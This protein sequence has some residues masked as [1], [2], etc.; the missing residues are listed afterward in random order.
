MCYVF[1]YTIIIRYLNEKSFILL[2]FHIQ[3]IGLKKRNLS[4]CA[5]CCK[6]PFRKIRLP[7][8]KNNFY[9]NCK[10]I[11]LKVRENRNYPLT[12]FRVGKTF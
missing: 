9:A 12:A 4:N 8:L 11:V 3:L 1:I 6:I 10:C 5:F 2:Y 7:S